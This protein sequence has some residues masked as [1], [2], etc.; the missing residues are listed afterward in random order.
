MDNLLNGIRE[1]H[2]ALVRHR[3]PKP[4]NMMVVRDDPERVV[5]IDFDRAE[6][7]N[8]D[9]ITNEQ[10]HLLEEEEEIIVN[11]KECLVSSLA[12]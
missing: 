6:T 1:I 4:R 11:F 12:T 9:Q 10:K 7:Y 8:K 2:S 5:W 3:D